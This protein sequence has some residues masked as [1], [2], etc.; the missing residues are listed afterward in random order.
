MVRVRVTLDKA[1]LRA[2]AIRFSRPYVRTITRRI[3]NR[4]Q[5]LVRVDTGYLRASGRMALVES[6]RGPRGLVQYTA[7]YAAAVHDG[8]GPH[9]IRAR[10]KKALRF[11]YQGREVIVKSVRHPGNRGAP[12]LAKAA[13]EVASEAG[14][15]W[16][17]RN[18]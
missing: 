8:A 16:R 14:L 10:K 9:I 17:P 12:F 2:D 5:V 11:Q 13:E 15:R 7:K 3:F 18:Q 4:S 1:G 6:A